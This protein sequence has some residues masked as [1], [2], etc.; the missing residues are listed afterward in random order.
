[1]RRLEKLEQ[2]KPMILRRW[3]RIIGETEADLDAQTAALRASPEW[4]EGNGVIRRLIV[5]PP[6]RVAA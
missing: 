2:A 4:S 6:H 3:H 5:K 1:M